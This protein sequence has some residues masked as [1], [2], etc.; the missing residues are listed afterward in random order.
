MQQ[1]QNVRNSINQ[2]N[3]VHKIE[4]STYDPVI[5]DDVAAAIVAANK[6]VV[7]VENITEESESTEVAEV[8]E[9]NAGFGADVISEKGL[10]TNSKVEDSLET[11]L[12]YYSFPV[13]TSNM[14]TSAIGHY[15]DSLKE[16][17][18]AMK[19]NLELE[20]PEIIKTFNLILYMI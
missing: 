6:K 8:K 1:E 12:E 4:L 2:L 3:T 15:E 5:K 19:V 9:G 17:V 10:Y 18:K 14:Y 16:I 11:Y 20:E 13:Y 7:E